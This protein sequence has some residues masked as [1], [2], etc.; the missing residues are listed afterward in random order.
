M[1]LI[2]KIFGTTGYKVTSPMGWRTNPVT[3]KKQ[4][5]SGVDYV[6]KPY[7]TKWKLYAVETG[8]VLTK[9]YN[10][11]SGNYIWV[12]YPRI[13]RALLHCH[14]SSVKV[15]KGQAVK[16]GTLIGYAGTTG[17]STGIHLHLGMTKIGSSTWLNPQTYVYTPA[18]AT[19][20]PSK[21]TLSRYLKYGSTGTAVKSLQKKLGV[22]V[23]GK[24]GK[25]TLAALKKWQ[26]KK[27]LKADGIVGKQT[28]NKLGWKWIK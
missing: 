26:K 5:H 4:Y 28:C 13:N 10:S 1:K 19:T 27:G 12:R 9:G 7:G 11:V 20:T 22:K 23:D 6:R 14:L 3:K 16:S 2:T 25:K 24:F 17:S 21:P 18:T 8:Y 15:K